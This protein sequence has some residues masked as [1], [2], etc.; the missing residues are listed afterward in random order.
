MIIKADQE[1][2]DRITELGHLALKVLINGSIDVE[3]S[4]RA[5]AGV[6]QVLTAIELIEEPGNGKEREDKAD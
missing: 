5:A 1:A 3:Q 6:Q 4:F 2:K